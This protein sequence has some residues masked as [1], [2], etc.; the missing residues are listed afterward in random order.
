[1]RKID[2]L[3]IAESDIGEIIDF[4]AKEKNSAAEQW[5]NNLEK[6]ISLLANQPPLGSI[7]KDQT[8]AATGVRFL[9]VGNFLIFYVVMP[10]KIQI[11]RVLHAK[12]DYMNLLKG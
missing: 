9:V 3:P 11:R 6:N 10:K 12:R 4:I 8:I 5:L 1:M 2:I 7:P